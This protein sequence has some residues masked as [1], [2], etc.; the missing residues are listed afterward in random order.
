MDANAL[1]F[2]GELSYPNCQLNFNVKM[3]IIKGYS[4]YYK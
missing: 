1:G 4:K 3:T 2:D